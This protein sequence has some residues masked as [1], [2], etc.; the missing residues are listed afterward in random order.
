MTDPKV[1]SKPETLNDA[2]RARAILAQVAPDIKPEAWFD[3][4]LVAIAQALAEA[5]RRAWN[6]A[7]DEAAAITQTEG[8][9]QR[10]QHSLNEAVV[11]EKCAGRIRALKRPGGSECP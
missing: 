1:Y 4:E 3:F 2:E 8:L 9:R 5:E 6:E 11:L 7:V 10:Q